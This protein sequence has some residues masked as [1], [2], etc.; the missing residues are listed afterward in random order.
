M[1]IEKKKYFIHLNH[2]NPAI[3]K[4]SSATNIINSKRFNVAREEDLFNL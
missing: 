2:T 4:S 1:R 3:F